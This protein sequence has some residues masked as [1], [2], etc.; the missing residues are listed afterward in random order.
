MA[1]LGVVA[2]TR[3]AHAHGFTFAIPEGW[4]D[5]SR[6]TKQRLGATDITR[7]HATT[8]TRRRCL[9][10]EDNTEAACVAAGAHPPLDVDQPS[11]GR[12][13]TGRYRGSARALGCSTGARRD[14]PRP[15]PTAR[16][17][18]SA[19]GARATCARDASCVGPP[20]SRAR[21]SKGQARVTALLAT[22]VRE[23]LLFRHQPFRRQ[24]HR[25]TPLL[26]KCGNLPRQDRGRSLRPMQS[27]PV[28]FRY[29]RVG[30]SNTGLGSPI[31]PA[32]R[33]GWRRPCPS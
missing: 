3:P 30:G 2:A 13:A 18:R 21:P 4:V 26:S 14:R 29:L 23:G 31:P 16:A 11:R 9:R 32:D 20:R 33:D 5:F 28:E 8:R 27:N 17:R 12:G 25:N 10:H 24:E 1:L 6:G 19:T 7:T 15:A 22:F